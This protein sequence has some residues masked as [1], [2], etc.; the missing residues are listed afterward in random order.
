M[1]NPKGKCGYIY[2]VYVLASEWRK[3][4]ARALMHQVLDH[5]D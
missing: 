1:K 2:D 5:L 3:G 4:I